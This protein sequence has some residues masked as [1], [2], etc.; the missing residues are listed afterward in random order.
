MTQLKKLSTP[1]VLG[2]QTQGA[3]SEELDKIRNKEYTSL[4]NIE[5]EK[6]YR[7]LLFSAG[8]LDL[9][10]KQY[11]IQLNYCANP[12]CKWYGQSQKRYE[13]KNK[14][15]RYKLTQRRDEPVIECNEILADTTYGLVLPHKTNTISNWSIA[16]EV[17]RLVSINSVSI[18]D[19][20]YT[21]HKDDCP[22]AFET[23]FSNRKAF[24][25]RGKSP[26]K[27]VRYQCKQCRK[28]TNVLPNQEENFG[29]RQKRN[30]ILIQL[31]KDLLSRTPVKRTCEKLEIGASTYY[32]KLEWIYSKCIEFLE[33]HETTP[34]RDKSFK[35]LW[36][37]TD[38]FVYI[39]N[40]IRQKGMRKH[41]GDESIDKQFPTHMI[42][43]AD[44]KTGYVFRADIDYDFNVTLDGIEED[45]QK[46]HCDHTYSFL[47]K[48]ER[49]RYP[50]CP[51]R[52]T[53]SDRQSEL[54]YMAE[55]HD[56]EL[57]KN[58]VEGSHTKRTYTA[59]AHFWLLK[60]M[61]DV[62]EW[63][64][65]SDNDA[66]L[67]SAVFRV[68]SDVFLSGYGNYFT[69]QNDKTLSLQDSGAE[70]FK[71]RRTLSRWGNLHGLWEESME[72]LALKKLQE[73]LKHHQFYEYQTNSS[74]QFPV[75]GKNTIK[76]PLP[77]KDEGIR[78]VNVISDLTRISSDEMAKLIFQVNS[79]AINNFYQTL[80]RRLSILERPLVTARG[81][82]KSYIYA[83][84]NPKYAQ[85]VTTILRTFYNFC[86]ATKLN[87]ELAT[88]AQRLGI[89]DRKYTYRDIIY[90]H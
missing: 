86:W 12:F 54:E 14:P 56:F 80:R 23:P 63:F 73:E 59:I 7:H 13:S 84:Y 22:M 57:R 11:S 47:R 42:A 17:K 2:I 6:K 37:N 8:I 74:Q 48:N 16:E 34:L 65:V 32:H 28:L 76:H 45:T 36:L 9:N 46:Y 35:E 69:C 21:F 81:D 64:F 90:F 40:N 31:T 18:I 83:N 44:L 62:K 70:F 53:P 78:W 41:P 26:G 25:T 33:R 30:D 55:L 67:E 49:L 71:A 50:F 89:A 58:Y 79:R 39:L 60:Q 52:P 10:G 75:R 19:K 4:S 77:Y 72:S 85:Y 5:F 88:P 3:F 15:S 29:Y 82:G 87:G 51:Q 68:F 61:L 66:T 1:E 27:A 38:E 43:S 20:D 24:Y